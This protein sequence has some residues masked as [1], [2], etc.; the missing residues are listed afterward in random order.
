MTHVPDLDDT[1]AG[2]LRKLDQAV[3][4]LRYAD[5]RDP[6]AFHEG[7]SEIRGELSKLAAELDLRPPCAV[8]EPVRAALSETT[9]ASPPR[10]LDC[11]HCRRRRAAQ[12]RRHRL[13]LP[14][15]DLFQWADLALHCGRS[16][17]CGKQAVCETADL[18]L[19][20]KKE[21]Q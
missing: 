19:G 5:H 20:A 13:R 6:E 2:R 4:R 17:Q 1:P 10:T 9:S 3:A 16:T 14:G 12:S 21:I 8:M 18:A 7:K 15:I 11:K